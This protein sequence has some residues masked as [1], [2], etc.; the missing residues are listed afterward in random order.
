M[1]NGGNEYDELYKNNF[2]YDEQRHT[3]DMFAN[4]GARR[5]IQVPY[6]G[7]AYLPY[8][9]Y[10]EPSAE[11]SFLIFLLYGTIGTLGIAVKNNND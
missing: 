7:R 8:P 2:A 5:L 10:Y 9:A 4:Q 11:G 3:W 6:A 1:E